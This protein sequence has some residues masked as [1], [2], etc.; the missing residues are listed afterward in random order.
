VFTRVQKRKGLAVRAPLAQ[1]NRARLV[2]AL[3]S[4]I[5]TVADH[6]PRGA[7]PAPRRAPAPRYLSRPRSS[8]RD[9]EG[10][11]SGC[12]TSGGPT[13]QLESSLPPGSPGP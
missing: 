8:V 12:P 1:G 6:L 13:L 5:R 3:V 10:V 4:V 2:D 7:T 9:G 11:H